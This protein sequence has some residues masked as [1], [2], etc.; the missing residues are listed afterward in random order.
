MNLISQ[1]RYAITNALHIYR[2]PAKVLAFLQTVQPISHYCLSGQHSYTRGTLADT[3][4]LIS[5][6][7]VSKNKNKDQ[8]FSF[9]LRNCLVS[10]IVT[11]LQFPS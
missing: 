10:F 4:N 2:R 11:S 8:I 9:L 5:E 7:K 6:N 3:D 1:F